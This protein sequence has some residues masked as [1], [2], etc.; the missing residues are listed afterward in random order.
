MGNLKYYNFLIC[1]I[2]DATLPLQ[3]FHI[4]NQIQQQ[5]TLI[6]IRRKKAIQ[7][8]ISLMVGIIRL[9]GK[10]KSNRNWRAWW[11][12]AILTIHNFVTIYPYFGTFCQWHIAIWNTGDCKR[13]WHCITFIWPALSRNRVGRPWA[14]RTGSRHDMGGMGGINIISQARGGGV[15]E[16]IVRDSQHNTLIYVK[17]QQ[18]I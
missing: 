16:G 6:K 18:L 7:E 2:G 11:F 1:A 4:D 14:S 9:C 3:F 10:P 13:P 8:T 15:S 12:T 5:G 17:I